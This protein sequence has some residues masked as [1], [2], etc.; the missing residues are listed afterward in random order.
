MTSVLENISYTNRYTVKIYRMED[1]KEVC[2]KP[3]VNEERR[4]YGRSI[5]PAIELCARNFDRPMYQLMLHLCYNCQ[6]YSSE[7]DFFETNSGRWHI[8][9]QM[10]PRCCEFNRA[11]QEAAKNVLIRYAA[12]EEELKQT[13]VENS[14]K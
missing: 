8:N 7:K 10:C 6:K 5:K 2:K 1:I 14:D 12:Q 3:F 11:C 4:P 13:K 9:I